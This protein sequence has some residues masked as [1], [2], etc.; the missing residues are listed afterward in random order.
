MIEFDRLS[1][2]WGPFPSFSDLSHMVIYFLATLLEFIWFFT[3]AGGSESHSIHCPTK[4]AV[5]D[6]DIGTGHPDVPATTLL[7]GTWLTQERPC[8]SVYFAEFFARFSQSEPFQSTFRTSMRFSYFLLLLDFAIII[9]LRR[10]S[11]Y[12][13]LRASFILLNLVCYVWLGFSSH[14]IALWSISNLWNAWRDVK[15]VLLVF[16]CGFGQTI[17]NCSRTHH[18]TGTVSNEATS[19][20]GY[21]P[22]RTCDPISVVLQMWRRLRQE[23]R[24]G[25]S[26]VPYFWYSSH[27]FR[28]ELHDG[29]LYEHRI[30]CRRDS[31]PFEW[32]KWSSSCLVCVC[33]C[34]TSEQM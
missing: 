33:V 10:Y 4:T 19:D 9:I 22:G 30:S 18:F 25:V 21:P 32:L 34:G 11:D 8:W 12:Y 16:T 23:L 20:M 26:T 6:C 1:N 29:L 15:L 28:C 3:T 7:N 27:V 17:F 2:P 14:W 13:V 31:I 5:W 24:G